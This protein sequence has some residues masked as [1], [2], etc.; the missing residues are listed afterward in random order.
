LGGI[1]IRSVC[2]KSTN[3]DGSTSDPS[4][5]HVFDAEVD[6]AVDFAVP[7]GAF[8]L[9]T[10]N[11]GINEVQ[12]V[13]DHNPADKEKCC[14]WAIGNFPGEVCRRDTEEEADTREDSERV[15]RHDG[16]KIV[17]KMVNSNST[18]G[19]AKKDFVLGD[20]EGISYKVLL[21]ASLKLLVATLML[22]LDFNTGL[23]MSEFG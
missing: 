22:C 18:S 15:V 9:A 7:P 5:E 1:W 8:I 2:Q 14:P 23:L 4:R 20:R 6:V 13:E 3:T 16:L 11:D 12:E 10:P 17:G 19:V 21:S